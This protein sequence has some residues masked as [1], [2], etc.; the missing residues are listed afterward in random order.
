MVEVS[1][2][3]RS[4]QWRAL[5]CPG[6]APEPEA[7][8]AAAQQ[9]ASSSSSS[10]G[11]SSDTASS[12]GGGGSNGAS[13]SSRSG[14]NGA[15]VSWH[16]SLEEVQP[17]GPTLYIAH[18]FL[19]ALPVHQFQKTGGGL[20]VGGATGCGTAALDGWVAWL[21]GG[22]MPCAACMQLGARAKRPTGCST[23]LV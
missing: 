18:E 8:A 6:P 16:R 17:E 2:Q 21:C 4:M 11:D 23:R 5:R 15:H 22:A 13:I 12:Q 14:W 20:A 7:E 10:S 19:D 3:L 9:T 1:P